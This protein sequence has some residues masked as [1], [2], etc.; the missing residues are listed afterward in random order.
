MQKKLKL[1][2][3]AVLC[4]LLVLS[5]PGQIVHAK[6]ESKKSVTL[7]LTEEKAHRTCSFSC[8]KG[9][10]VKITVKVLSVSGKANDKKVYFA[11]VRSDEEGFEGPV[12]PDVKTNQFRKNKTFT[13]TQFVD[14]P[15]RSGIIY[16]SLPE[17]MEKMKIKVTFSSVEGKK[18]VKSLKKVD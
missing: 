9:A 11:G 15:C 7:T 12:F 16:F 3:A 4:F 13:S 8:K 2:A 1:M 14:Y 6:T 18:V 17:G 5:I 10:K